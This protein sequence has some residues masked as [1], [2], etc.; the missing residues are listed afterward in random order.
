MAIHRRTLRLKGLG[1][2]TDIAPMDRAISLGQLLHAHMTRGPRV[3]TQTTIRIDPASA[4]SIAE[5][6]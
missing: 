6:P 5:T 3:T 2:K 4:F 1:P